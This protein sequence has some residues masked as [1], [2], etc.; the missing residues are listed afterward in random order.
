MRLKVLVL[1]GLPGSGKSAY[2]KELMLKEKDEWVRVSRD[3]LR[4]MLYF[5]GFSRAKED[6]LVYYMKSILVDLL[7][8]GY[9][10]IVDNIHLDPE[11]ITLI[12]EAILFS[13]IDCETEI[14]FIDTPLEECIARDSLRSDSVGAKV[15]RKLYD[16]WLA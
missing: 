8:D 3:N 13:G 5:G 16:R 14:K 15:I 9:N 2:A 4:N 1:K 10:V 6:R 11:H 12:H 7:R